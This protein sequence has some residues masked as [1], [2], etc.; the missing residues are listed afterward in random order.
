MRRRTDRRLQARQFSARRQYVL[1]EL[2]SVNEVVSAKATPEEA[3]AFR[4][5]LL[6][7]AQASADAAKEGGFMGFGAELVSQGEQRM[8]DEVRSALGITWAS[9]VLQE[10]HPRLPPRPM[11]GE[12]SPASAPVMGP[13][14]LVSWSGM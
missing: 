5:W 14:G 2:R 11:R 8:L 7:V 1:D 10:K 3:D 13:A 6:D 9:G 12:S 4:G